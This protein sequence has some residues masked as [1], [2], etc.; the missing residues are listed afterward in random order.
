MLGQ[1]ILTY[2]HPEDH[3]FLKQQIVPTNLETLFDVNSGDDADEGR[4]RTQ[5]EEDEIDR[6]LKAD[7]RKFTI[8]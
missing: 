7:K 3:V 1:N 5:E 4:V 2:T 8:R 6:K